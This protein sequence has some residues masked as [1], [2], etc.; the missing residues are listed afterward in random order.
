M[1]DFSSSLTNSNPFQSLPIRRRVTFLDSHTEDPIRIQR[2]TQHFPIN[3]DI[4]HI[5]NYQSKILP[6]FP[7]T[8]CQRWK[9]YSITIMLQEVNKWFCNEFQAA[10]LRRSSSRPYKSCPH[11]SLLLTPSFPSQSQEPE[12]KKKKKKKAADGK[13]RREKMTEIDK[14]WLNWFSILAVSVWGYCINLL[15]YIFESQWVY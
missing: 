14:G 13:E 11:L 2:E 10:K 3:D 9:L 15:Y 7:V 6:A 1:E 8:L 4:Q 5:E 12:K